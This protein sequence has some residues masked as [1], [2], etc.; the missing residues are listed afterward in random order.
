VSV[1][2]HQDA[3]NCSAVDRQSR[4]AALTQTYGLMPRALKA[5]QMASGLHIDGNRSG[6]AIRLCDNQASRRP[7]GGSG[8]TSATGCGPQSLWSEPPPLHSFFDQAHRA[9]SESSSMPWLV[10]TQTQVRG[11]L[12]FS[13]GSQMRSRELFLRGVK[14]VL[15][16]VPPC[17]IRAS[18][19]VGCTRRATGSLAR[20]IGWGRV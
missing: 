6:V 20:V 5:S 3:S 8:S 14:V 7:E 12:E 2:W 4:T 1:K 13:V 11:T 9:T 17:A 19:V 15:V 18:G 10:A 16:I